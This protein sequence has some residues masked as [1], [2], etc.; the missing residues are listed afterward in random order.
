[1]DGNGETVYFQVPAALLEFLVAHLP[2]VTAEASAKVA[3]PPQ[4]EM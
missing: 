4:S 1:M 2:F 3:G